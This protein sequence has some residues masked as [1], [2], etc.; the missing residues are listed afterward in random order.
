MLKLN[1]APTFKAKVKIPEPGGVVHDVTF[2]FK[3]RTRDGLR[4]LL[5]SEEWRNGN[6]VDNVLAMVCGWEGVEAPFGR[7]GVEQLVQNYHAAP[8]L[9]ASAYTLELT[10]AR[11]GN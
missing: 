10:Q 1:P 8:A 2:E 4:E 5:A 7:E 6:D 3:H 9:I 11:L